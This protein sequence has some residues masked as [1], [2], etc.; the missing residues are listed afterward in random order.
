MRILECTFKDGVPTAAAA[1]ITIHM[2]RSISPP[3]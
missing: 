2:H 1:Q 3:S